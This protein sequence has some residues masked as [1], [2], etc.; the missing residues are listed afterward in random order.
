MGLRQIAMEFWE[1]INNDQRSFSRGKMITKSDVMPG[2]KGAYVGLLEKHE[3]CASKPD[4]IGFIDIGW[5][6]M[7]DKLMAGMKKGGW[8]GVLDYLGS[9][10]GKLRFY[11]P[12][13]QPSGV[14]LMVKL[15]EEKSVSVC[16]RCGADGALIVKTDRGTRS[17]CKACSSAD[18]CHTPVSE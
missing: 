3:V 1:A 17:M 13:L 18:E 9:K 7:I 14:N 11:V 8:D 4:A 10:N 6:P 5:V 2:A 15:A 16:E 12:P